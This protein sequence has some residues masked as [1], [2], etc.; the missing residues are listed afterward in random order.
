MLFTNLG[1]FKRMKLFLKFGL[2]FALLLGGVFYLGLFLGKR[3]AETTYFAERGV[4]DPARAKKT[5][6]NPSATQIQD[7]TA[8]VEAYD[9]NSVVINSPPLPPNL[10]RIMRDSGIIERMGAYLDAVRVMDQSNVQDVI[11]AFE[12]L[13]KGY[14]RHLE[15]K[16]LMRSWAAIDPVSAL[17]YAK[18]NLDENTERRFG[19]TEVLAGWAKLDKNAAL[20]WA[21]ENNSV[22]RPEDNP[23]LIGVIKGLAEKNSAE[24]DQLL[25][26]LPPGNAKWQASTYLAQEYSKKST[27]E[28]VAWANDFPTDDPRLRETILG[29]ISARLAR[30]DTLGTAKWVLSMETDQA[31][32]RV[33][34]NLMT[35]WVSTDAQQASGWVTALKDDD[36]KILAMK[37]L[38]SRWSLVDPVATA[39]WLNG[40]PPSPELDP[41]VGEF[42]DRISSRDPEGAAGWASSIVD[43]QSKKKALDRVLKSWEQVD[44]EG[45]RAWFQQNQNR[46]QN[47]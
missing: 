14:G 38:A 27:A 44:P 29:Q 16:L 2:P 13:P 23:Y 43:P 30:Q 19:V 31:S 21:N 32:K 25:K 11:V 15:M 47:P 42:V 45:S 1:Y 4:V 40:F 6:L 28:A 3:E 36:T 18:R 24:A 41:V 33:M 34:D 35:H 37:Q 9:S 17:Q 5:E 12:A 10:L 22:A 7:Q 26:D 8:P 46:T 39:E 20:N